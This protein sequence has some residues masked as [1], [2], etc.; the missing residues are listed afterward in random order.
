MR[1]FLKQRA[2]QAVAAVYRGLPVV[3]LDGYNVAELMKL[4]CGMETA[5]YC[6]R[7]LPRTRAFYSAQNQ[8]SGTLRQVTLDGL[9]MEF[10]VAAGRTVNYIADRT[11]HTVHGFDSFQGLPEDWRTGFPKGKFAQ[12]QVPAV[13]ANVELH[14]GLFED[15]LPAFLRQ[16]DD[17][18]A[19]VHIDCCLYASTKTVLEALAS[20][21]V[22]GTIVVFGQYFNH[23]TWRT[24]EWLAFQEF[25]AQRSISYD[26]IGY[27]PTHQQ[28]AVRIS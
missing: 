24:D 27:V 8:I 21:I 26:Y 23:P 17:A 28:A 13:R 12:Q 16:R 7:H 1:F 11:P 14:V 5:E 10:G 19:F 9:Y 6:I 2:Q 20:R 25:V 18:V 4:Q 3:G 15:T 22:P